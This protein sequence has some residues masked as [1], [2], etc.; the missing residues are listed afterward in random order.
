MAPNLPSFLEKS[1]LKICVVL[2][3]F[4]D[5]IYIKKSINLYID[6]Y[7]S[8]VINLIPVTKK[9]KEGKIRIEIK[10]KKTI[11]NVV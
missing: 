1:I 8:S 10:P 11:K 9:T 4:N 3:T 7:I 5:S 2:F 6:I